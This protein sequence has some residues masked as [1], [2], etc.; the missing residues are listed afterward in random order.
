M[1]VSV[2]PRRSSGGFDGIGVRRVDGG[3]LAGRLVVRQIADIVL[4][5]E[6]GFDDQTHGASFRRVSATYREVRRHCDDPGRQAA[7]RFLQV[8]AGQRGARAGARRDRPHG[9]RC[10]GRCASS[11]LGFAT[12]YLRFSLP[13]GR[14]RARLHAGA[15]GVVRLAAR[16]SVAHGAL[17][18]ARNAADR[19]GG[20]SLSSRCTPSS[21]RRTPR[22]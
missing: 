7:D 2:Q 1:S 15:A 11:G 14:A 12:P 13:N 10:R 6:E 20:R 18:S 17:R 16:G 9:G 5:A 4:A 22:S 19:R 3:G 8:A 21:I